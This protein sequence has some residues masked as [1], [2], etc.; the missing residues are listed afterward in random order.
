MPRRTNTICPKRLSKS[1]KPLRQRGMGLLVVMLILV[2]LLAWVLIGIAQNGS[3][4]SLKSAHEGMRTSDQRAGIMVAQ[5]MSQNGIQMAYQWL[6][7]QGEPPNDV[8]A[9]AP[10]QSDLGVGF[11]GA[12]SAGGYDNYT[13]TNGTYGNGTVQV[14]FYPQKSNGT[15]NRKAFLIESIGIFNGRKQIYHAVVQQET[16]AKFAY[17]LDTA[18]TTWWVTGATVFNG[19]VH[20]N[21][22]KTDGSGT[23]DPAATIKIGWRSW[24][25]DPVFRYPGDEAFTTSLPDSQIVWKEMSS[26]TLVD[27]AYYGR[28]MDVLAINKAPKTNAP[29]IHMPSN[30][31]VQENGALGG[32]TAPTA[33]GTTVPNDGSKTVGGVYVEGDVTKINLKVAGA[34]DTTQIVEIFQN[35]SV[36]GDKTRTTVTLDRV[37]NQTTIQRDVDSGTGWTS[38]GSSTYADVTNGAIYVNGNIGVVGPPAVGGLSGIVANAVMSG[39]TV[40]KNSSLNIITPADKTCN[41]SGGIVYANLLDSN[42]NPNN[43]IASAT[44]GT[45]QSGVMGIVAGHIQVLE[46]DA[47]GTPI[48]DLSIHATVFASEI[49]DVEIPTTR[50]PGSLKILGGYIVKDSGKFG[51]FDSATNSLLSGFVVTRNYDTR[52]NSNPPPFFPNTGNVYTILSMTKAT[53]PISP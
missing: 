22:L 16:F 38:L 37:G 4:S 33:K 1:I 35:D 3:G 34:G 11:F 41:L 10:S 51:V 44:A 53:A 43:P 24:W 21:G 46:N 13:V 28:W 25:D 2:V 26:R 14:R 45:N 6:T 7:E 49:F 36:T 32:I 31:T 52:V 39:T 15:Q 47:G 9:F 50:T 40:L 23:L 12:T 48:T 20:I 8:K 18:P 5:Q 19:P 27:P 42:A 30:N 17:F 29:I